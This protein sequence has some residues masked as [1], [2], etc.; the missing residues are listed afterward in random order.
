MVRRSYKSR[1]D[2]TSQPTSSNPTPAHTTK[3]PTA[4]PSTPIPSHK[5]SQKPTIS[6]E[7]TLSQPTSRPIIGDSVTFF[8]TARN[9]LFY[10]FGVSP[11]DLEFDRMS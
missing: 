6:F 10:D 9:E 2:T 5:P 8:V 3:S 4:A 1:A 7:P 11:I